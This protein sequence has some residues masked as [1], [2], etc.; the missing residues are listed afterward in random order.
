[1]SI[2]DT[3]R[4]TEV[5]TLKDLPEMG[6][7]AVYTSFG[8]RG[9]SKT[10]ISTTRPSLTVCSLNGKDISVFRTLPKRRGIGIAYVTKF[11]CFNPTKYEL[12][13]LFEDLKNYINV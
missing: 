8:P 7:R 5:V 2:F 3:N 1:M 10:M 6:Y 9:Y 11:V 4:A 13:V 12:E